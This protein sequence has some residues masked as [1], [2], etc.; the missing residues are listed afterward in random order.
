M[1]GEGGVGTLREEPCGLRGRSA[2]RD[3]GKAGW[4]YVLGIAGEN[5]TRT[6]KKTNV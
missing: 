3:P 5:R 2:A 4:L 1:L 6:E